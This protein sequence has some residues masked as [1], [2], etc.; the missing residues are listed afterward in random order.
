[1]HEEIIFPVNVQ[2]GKFYSVPHIKNAAGEFIP[3]NSHLH[4][5]K[6]IINF[7]L[8]HWHVDWRFLSNEIY[9]YETSNCINSFI[10]GK[11][12]LCLHH[13]SEIGVWLPR[14]VTSSIQVVYL[15]RKCKR[16]YSAGNFFQENP[17]RVRNTNWVGELAKT[18]CHSKLKKVG[19]K[20]I[21]PHKGI[22]I[23]ES[24]KD[25]DGNY[26]CP[27]HLL[28]FNPETLQVVQH[29]INQ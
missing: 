6:K 28:K 24:C 1:M 18:F 9:E 13:E 11:T 22:V 27:G 3:I 2:V 12:I 29:T 19:G 14:W 7:P 26:V 20:L 15:K 4:E 17:G 25:L 10:E 5:D 8:K 23:D 21:C 16:S